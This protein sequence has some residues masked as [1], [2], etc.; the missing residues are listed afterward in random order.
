MLLLGFTKITW[1][2]SLVRDMLFVLSSFEITLATEIEGN[3]SNTP[4]SSMH[5]VSMHCNFSF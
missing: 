4:K 3:A 2:H 1:Y 5:G